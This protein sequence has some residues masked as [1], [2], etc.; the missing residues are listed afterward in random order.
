MRGP[1]CIV[2]ANLTPSSLKVEIQAAIKPKAGHRLVTGRQFEGEWRDSAPWSGL[3]MWRG[4]M[5]H[6]FDGNWRN[7]RP[8]EGEFGREFSH[9]LLLKLV[10]W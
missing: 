4:R 5:A 6:V 3:G 8:Y 1:T 7:G 9:F 10:T 2:W